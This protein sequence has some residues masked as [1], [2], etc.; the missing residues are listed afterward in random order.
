MGPQGF[1]AERGAE[2]RERCQAQPCR[3]GKSRP[4][5][6]SGDAQPMMPSGGITLAVSPNGTRQISSPGFCVQT[7]AQGMA[8]KTAAASQAVIP[9]VVDADEPKKLRAAGITGQLAPA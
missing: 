2:E 5:D 9:S 1:H 3:S 7:K 8:S 6:V 4:A